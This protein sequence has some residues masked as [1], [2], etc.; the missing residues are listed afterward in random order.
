MRFPLI[1]VQV[2]TWKAPGTFLFCLLLCGLV[3]HHSHLQRRRTV[4]N[5]GLRHSCWL[6]FGIHTLSL[7]QRK[8]A[9]PLQCM[10]DALSGGQGCQLQVKEGVI[11]MSIFIP[12]SFKLNSIFS[13]PST[14]SSFFRLLTSPQKHT[15]NVFKQPSGGK[16]LCL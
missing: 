10:D 4:R 9:K 1:F 12:C 7:W 11:K 6:C 15:V 16:Q 14:Y 5:W 2:S 8:A 13:G 3:Y